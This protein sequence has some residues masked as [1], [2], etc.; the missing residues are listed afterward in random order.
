M[1]RE[2]PRKRNHFDQKFGR[3]ENT[4]QKKS[5]SRKIA[6]FGFLDFSVLGKFFRAGRE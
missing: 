6:E 2:P 1:Q 3:A 5:K 4:S